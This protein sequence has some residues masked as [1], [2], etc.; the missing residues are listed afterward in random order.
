MILLSFRCI[1][2][3]ADCALFCRRS[4]LTNACARLC[5]FRRLRFSCSHRGIQGNRFVVTHGDCA[6]VILALRRCGQGRRS[7]IKLRQFTH[8]DLGILE[9]C[10]R[11]IHKYYWY[12]LRSYRQHL[13]L[14]LP[15]FAFACRDRGKQETALFHL[16]TLAYLTHTS[17]K[18]G[19]IS[20]QHVSRPRNFCTTQIKVSSVYLEQKVLEINSV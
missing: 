20:C 15:K 17:R 4:D 10:V 8:A 14:S 16:T 6:G 3:Q 19:C 11:N 18:A 9:S 2:V 13:T 5:C 12:V 7:S 1:L